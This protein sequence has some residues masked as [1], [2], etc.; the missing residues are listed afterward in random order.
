MANTT[1]D[2]NSIA[3]QAGKA[4]GKDDLVF[5]NSKNLP[6]VFLPG[7]SIETYEN[8]YDDVTKKSRAP[9]AGDTKVQKNYL[10]YGLFLGA[11]EEQIVKICWAKSQVVEGIG[12]ALKSFRNAAPQ[13]D[14][15]IKADDF[16][17][18]VQVT[19]TGSGLGTE[20]KV[21]VVKKTKNIVPTAIWQKGAI[22]EKIKL[23]P[24]LSDMRDR[25]LGIKK[26]E[27]VAS[28]GGVGGSVSKLD[29]SFE[30]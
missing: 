9:V 8:V 5:L 28:A 22:L 19:S 17:T 16:I 29:N 27:V 12:A 1:V 24:T 7:P 18:F 26:E 4:K 20:Y 2:W 11:G 15:N 10:F 25:L 21:E 3:D 23:L 6:Q 30:L 14:S 13:F